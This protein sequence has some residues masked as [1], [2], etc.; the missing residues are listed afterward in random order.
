MT[1]PSH[2]SEGCTAAKVPAAECQSH[3]RTEYLAPS[4]LSDYARYGLFSA[5]VLLAVPCTVSAQ[6]QHFSIDAEARLALAPQDA[7]TQQA[8]L[9]LEPKWQRDFGASISATVSARLRVDIGDNLTPGPIDASGYSDINGPIELDDAVT[10]ELRDAYLDIE[11]GPAFL[12]LG[13]QQIIWGELE[14][15]RLLDV[16]NPQTFREFILDEFDKSRIGLWAANLEIPFSAGAAGDWTAQF[17]W[18]P[19]PTVSEIPA[20]DAVFEFQAPRFLFGAQPGIVPPA[21]VR[22]EA[23]DDLVNDAAYGARLA[24]LVGGWDLSLVAYSGID[25]EPVGRIDNSAQGPQVVRS[26]ARREVFG[27]SAVTTIGP[28][29]ARFETSVQ[30]GRTFT[31]NNPASALGQ[32]QADQIGAALALDVMAPSETYLSFQVLYD[33]VLDAPDGLVRPREDILAS[34]YAR[35]DFNRGDIQTS[36]RWLSADSGVDGVISPEV[37]WK[38]D[39]STSVGVAADVFYGDR[40][41]VFGQFDNRDRL[42]VTLKKSF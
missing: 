38:I 26:H 34:V 14:G 18:V 30:P 4:G 17:I 37:T 12:R 42:T 36:M 1:Q 32:A 13:K 19:D 25:P 40:D 8:E 2:S 16:V 35:R 3:L 31:T 41:S 10:L 33:R 7:S 9:I 28:V 27:G 29:T 24:G 6:N 5:I 22:T 21:G 11:A 15:Y 39:D 20:S 23:P